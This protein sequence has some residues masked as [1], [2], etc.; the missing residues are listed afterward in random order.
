MTFINPETND[1]IDVWK[2]YYTDLELKIPQNK[3]GINPGLMSLSEKIDIIHLYGIPS[4][5]KK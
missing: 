2:D 5:M 1:T 3:L 4:G